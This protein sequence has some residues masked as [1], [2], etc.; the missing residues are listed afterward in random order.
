[1]VSRVIYRYTATL[2]TQNPLHLTGGAGG[3]WRR[4]LEREVR[5]GCE[6]REIEPEYH[7]PAAVQ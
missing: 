2:P 3:L 5:L 6:W 7:R 4:Y 1:M